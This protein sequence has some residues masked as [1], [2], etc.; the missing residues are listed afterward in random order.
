MIWTEIGDWGLEIDATK[1]PIS[2]LQSLY[3]ISGCIGLEHQVRDDNRL[4][5]EKE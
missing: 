5:G 4:L 1:S 3:F 2:N